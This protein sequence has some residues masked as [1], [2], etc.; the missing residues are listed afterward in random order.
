MRL[1]PAEDQHYYLGL[2][3]ESVGSYPE[4]RAEWALYA[5]VPD[6]PYRARALDH[7]AAID[8]QRRAR[9]PVP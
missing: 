8:A 3:Y 1:A 4:A 2:L 5:E 9:R 6:L 7:I